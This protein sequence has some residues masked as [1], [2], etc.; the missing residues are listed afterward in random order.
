MARPIQLKA[1]IGEKHHKLT[2]I[3]ID[4]SRVEC[5]CDCGYKIKIKYYRLLDGSCK[6]CGCLKLKFLSEG[7]V[8][9]KRGALTVVEAISRS[10]VK[11]VCDCGNV[12][13]RLA[14]RFTNGYLK[15]SSTCPCKIP[16]IAVPPTQ[17]LIDEMV[18]MTVGDLTVESY[19]ED[20]KTIKAD[21]TQRMWNCRCSCGN[22]TKVSTHDLKAKRDGLARIKDH[23]G[24]QDMK[25]P[26]PNYN[27]EPGRTFVTEKFGVTFTLTVINTYLDTDGEVK[28]NYTCACNPNIIHKTYARFL[29]G[30]T[31]NCGCAKKHMHKFKFEE[32]IL[33]KEV[34]GKDFIVTELL[35]QKDGYR[36]YLAKCIC[37][38]EFT[39]YSNDHSNTKSCGCHL[40]RATLSRHGLSLDDFSPDEKISTPFN[41]ALLSE[42]SAYK[43]ADSRK[44]REFSLSIDQFRKLITGTCEYCGTRDHKKLIKGQE[45]DMYGI[46]RV[47]PHIGHTVDN[48]ISCCKMCNW[49]KNSLMLPDFLDIIRNFKFQKFEPISFPKDGIGRLKIPSYKSF[50]DKDKY[51]NKISTMTKEDISWLVGQNCFYCGATPQENF[52]RVKRSS[53]SVKK[54]VVYN[55]IDRVDSSK[56]HDRDN[57]VCCCQFCNMAKRNLS[58]DDFYSH[59]MKIRNNLRKH[60]VI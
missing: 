7:L 58:I 41:A 26:K 34:E 30:S 59:I 22:L 48:C 16:F 21:N 28:C 36:I 12:V 40:R 37:G 44:G 32:N 38:K 18:G 11:C 19:C 5:I 20:F 24:C 35:D 42:W 50:T 49:A 17:E 47:N 14:R 60:G 3:S 43:E 46:D 25:G 10:K 33:G 9:Q 53:I 13:E 56:L 4:G 1:T 51:G 55:S 27:F 2:I 39:L 23:C 57:V 31:Y 52:D 15:C 8:G 54:V 29:L 6:S 45:I